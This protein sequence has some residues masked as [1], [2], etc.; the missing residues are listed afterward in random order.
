MTLQRLVPRKASGVFLI[1]H[2]D[3]RQENVDTLQCAHCQA[4]WTPAWG[5]GKQR[6]WC[7]RCQ[8]PT[9]GKERC[10]KGCAP[11][12]RELEAMEAR[13]RLRRAVERL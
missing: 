13:D 12:E 6:G 5:S 4:V 10:E 11:W 8:G 1:D 3:G 7:Y 9:C 2:P